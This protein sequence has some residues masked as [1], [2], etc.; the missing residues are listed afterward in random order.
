MYPLHHPL[1]VN[2]PSIIPSG[3]ELTYFVLRSLSNKEEPRDEIQIHSAVLLSLLK[4][5]PRS[6]KPKIRGENFNHKVNQL[7]SSDHSISSPGSL[8]I[9]PYK[10]LRKSSKEFWLITS[11]MRLCVIT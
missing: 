8:V 9:M 1:P 7:A 6:L 11:A 3:P 10:E 2:N 5:L 4:V